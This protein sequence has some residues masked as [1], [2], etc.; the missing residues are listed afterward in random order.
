[1]NRWSRSLSSKEQAGLQR[2]VRVINL[3][4]GGGGGE[5]VM[6]SPN[7]NYLTPTFCD[8]SRLYKLEVTLVSS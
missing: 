4:M 6:N 7:I 3:V 8:S 2:V 5:A 1:M